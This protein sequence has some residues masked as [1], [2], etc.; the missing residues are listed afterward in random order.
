MS[1]AVEHLLQKSQGFLKKL[2]HGNPNQR[3]KLIRGGNPN[4]IKALLELLFNY[5]NFARKVKP[6][7]PPPQWHST[8]D[9]ITKLC[10][11][12]LPPRAVKKKILKKK[13]KTMRYSNLYKIGTVLDV[14][15]NHLPSL[16]QHVSQ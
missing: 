15:K 12:N 5:G 9:M 8:K 3:A 6:A 11:K 16:L 2:L 7:L 4:E 1:Q 10:L 13:A 14:L